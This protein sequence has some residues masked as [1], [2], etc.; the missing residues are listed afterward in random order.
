M[1]VQS[2]GLGGHDTCEY[3]PVFDSEYVEEAGGTVEQD[4][5]DNAL[6]QQ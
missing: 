6:V 3:D 5:L 1:C 4:G 2:L